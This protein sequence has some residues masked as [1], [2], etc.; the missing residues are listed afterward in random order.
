MRERERVQGHKLGRG[1]E[2]EREGENP[3]QAPCSALDAG[4]NLMNCEIMTWAE[5]QSWTL[6][7]LN[8][9]GT[10][11]KSIFILA[12]CG[13]C[14]QLP[15]TRSLFS[16]NSWGQKSEIKVLVG[17]QFLEGSELG[18]FLDS[19]SFWW[20]HFWISWLV[21]TWLQ[22]R[23]SSHLHITSS[24]CEGTGFFSGFLLGA[25]LKPRGLQNSFS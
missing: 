13:C 6:N 14:N 8:H 25:A 11:A 17:L 15:Q 18:V 22:S 1:R 23:L 2:R 5:I 21:A 9:P 7:R 20:L 19:S 3:M 4:L 24:S 16:H 10:L 12:S